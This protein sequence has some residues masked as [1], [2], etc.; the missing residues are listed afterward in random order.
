MPAA[1]RSRSILWLMPVIFALH[2]GEE[3]LTMP[4]WI[5]AHDAPLQELAAS[6]RVGSMAISSLARS[7]AGVAVAIGLVSAVVLIV[8]VGATRSARPGWLYAYAA[9]LGVLAL[10]VVSHVGQAV[11]F[12]GYVPGLYGAVLAVLPGSVV[13]YA[14]LFREGMLTPR[15]AAV[16]AAAG[17]LA[18]G[19]IVLA[20]HSLGRLVG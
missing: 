6:S 14:R 15:G 7:G 12:G 11:L 18:A 17:A 1:T 4:G 2:D 16:S 19:P 9:T 13:I 10:H 8:T 5:R 3:L 20:A